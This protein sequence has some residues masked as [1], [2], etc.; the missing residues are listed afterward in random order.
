MQK[1][2]SIDITDFDTVD[3]PIRNER[4]FHV[5][6]VLAYFEDPGLE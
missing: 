1:G 2:L 5:I 4:E 3:G 6:T